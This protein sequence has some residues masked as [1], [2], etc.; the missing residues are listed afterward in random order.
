[1]SPS[2]VPD[3]EVPVLVVGGGPSG[4]LMAHILAKFGGRFPIKNNNYYHMFIYWLFMVTYSSDTCHRKIRNT[5]RSAKSAC[6][7]PQDFGVLS[8]IRPGRECNT[9]DGH[10]SR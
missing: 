2:I 6:P 5:S 10:A 4:L 7:Q 9:A 3:I 1:M 8:A